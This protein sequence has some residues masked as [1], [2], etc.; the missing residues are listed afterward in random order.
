MEVLVAE[1]DGRLAGFATL[2][3]NNSE[4]GEGVL[5]GVAPFAQ[6]SGIYRSLP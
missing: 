2:R 3:M 6:G 4:E 1:V 5:F